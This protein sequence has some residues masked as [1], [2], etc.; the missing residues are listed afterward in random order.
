M[1][2]EL[3]KRKRQGT[4]SFQLIIGG[5]FLLILTGALLLMLPIASQDRQVTPFIEDLI[6]MFEAEHTDIC[7]RIDSTGVLD[8]DLKQEITDISADFRS[9]WKA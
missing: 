3:K 1:Q 8:D 2:T 9:K 5:F 7:S 6:R 4:G